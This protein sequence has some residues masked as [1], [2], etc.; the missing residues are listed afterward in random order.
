MPVGTS[1]LPLC[2]DCLHN[3][4]RALRKNTFTFHHKTENTKKMNMTLKPTNL[5]H[6]CDDIQEKIGK[7]IKCIRIQKD[8]KKRQEFLN[9]YI[10]IYEKFG[11]TGP[12]DIRTVGAVV[13]GCNAVLKSQFEDEIHD[14][15]HD[16]METDNGPLFFV[17][18]MGVFY[19]QIKERIQFYRLRDEVKC[20]KF[21]KECVDS[22][23]PMDWS[24]SSEDSDSEDE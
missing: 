23:D 6:L 3:R 11:S 2:V 10:V 24:D 18:T 15:I 16:I 13:K 21:F 22:Y 8:A 5:L 14:K 12:Y 1:Y 19:T 7:E 9:T 20:I 17:K 4:G